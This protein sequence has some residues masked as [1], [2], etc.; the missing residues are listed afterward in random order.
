MN[1]L[2]LIL[3]PLWYISSGLPRKK[4]SWV[5]G[6]NTGSSYADNSRYFFEYINRYHP[7]ITAIWITR[8]KAIYEKLK[9][10]G[11]QVEYGDS[12][13][14][15]WACLRASKGF[16]THGKLDL[17]NE[18]SNGM[19]LFNLWHGMPLKTIGHIPPKSWLKRCYY[20]LW[21][22]QKWDHF[23]VTSEKFQKVMEDYYINSYRP[24]KKV[25]L[26]GQPRFDQFERPGAEKL[27]QGYK[28]KFGEDVR[29][30]LY[31]PTYREQNEFAGYAKHGAI[32]LFDDYDYQ[33]DEMQANMEGL[34]AVFLVKM[35]P[36]ASDKIQIGAAHDRI[37]LVQ[38]NEIDDLYFLLK[39]MDML[40]SDYSSILFD[41]LILNKPIVHT[42]FDLD[43]Y[44]EI[45]S[46][47]FDYEDIISGPIVDN[48][49]ET[50][51]AIKSGLTTDN[52]TSQR[53][54]VNSSINSFQKPKGYNEALY[55]FCNAIR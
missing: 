42:V 6:S 35:H 16:T 32:N 33:G 41:Y 31:C 36:M 15:K 46:F 52:F 49:K 54:Q 12:W 40:L 8:S 30:V 43:Q 37:H 4:N 53:E 28:N 5:F 9:S 20:R 3:L 19:T 34:N 11:C 23:F 18:F 26:M 21:Y 13:K 51:V 39:D 10:D 44:R 50:I 38:D 47:N 1:L 29:F 45:R 25:T 27:V 48:W 24:I 17:C 55:Q 22:P 2:K 14:G 7:E